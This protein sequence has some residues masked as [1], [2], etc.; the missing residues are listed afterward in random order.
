MEQNVFEFRAFTRLKQIKYLLATCQI[1]DHYYW[2]TWKTGNVRRPIR[3]L[4]G[5]QRR[6]PRR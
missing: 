6:R 5:P 3:R 1:D 4:S 2:Q